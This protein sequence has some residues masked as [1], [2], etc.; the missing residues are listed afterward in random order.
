MVLKTNSIIAYKDGTKADVSNGIYNHHVSVMDMNRGQK[1]RFSC[2]KGGIMETLIE[3]LGDT[4]M[5]GSIIIGRSE[6]KYGNYY[7]SQDGVSS[8]STMLGRRIRF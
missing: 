2:G 5:G 1:V 7:S 3:T 6:D 8:R 4:A